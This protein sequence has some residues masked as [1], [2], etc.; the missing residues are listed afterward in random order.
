MNESNIQIELNQLKLLL[1]DFQQTQLQKYSE[2]Q[3]KHNQLGNK[4]DDLQNKYKELENKN[5][6]L[7]NKHDQLE[8]KYNDYVNKKN[9]IYYQRFLERK[10]LATHKR[11]IHGIT[12]ISTKDEHIE[13]KH[14]KNYKAALGQLLSYNHNDNKSLCAYFF[15]NVNDNQ[16]EQIIKLYKSKNVS[17]KKFIDTPDGIVIENVLIQN[18]DGKEMDNK[19]SNNR[20]DFLCWLDNNIEYKQGSILRLKDVCTMFLDKEIPVRLTSKYKKEIEKWITNNYPNNINTNSSYNN[21]KYKGWLHLHL[22]S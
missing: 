3:E 9:E 19:N 17:I 8:T 5:D 4:N 13:I 18:E 12:D 21:I 20:D 6:D 11:T 16:C 2:L 10:L 15:G 7:Q 1:I 22:K 14:W